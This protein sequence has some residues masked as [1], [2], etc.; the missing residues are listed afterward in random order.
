MKSYQNNMAD[1]DLVVHSL[2]VL[3]EIDGGGIKEIRRGVDAVKQ[4]SLEGLRKQE[5]YWEQLSD[6]GVITVI[7]KQSLRREMENIARSEA[8]ITYQ[9]TSLGYQSELLQDYIDTY[10]DLHDYIYTTLHLFD[11]MTVNTAIDDRDTFNQMFSNYYY[12]DKNH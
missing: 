2:K 3:T 4:Q 12:A 1:Q 6:D 10:N 7:E 9:A 11:D 8:A 5:A